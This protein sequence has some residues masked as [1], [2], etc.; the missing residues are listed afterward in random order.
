AMQT[1]SADPRRV[2]AVLDVHVDGVAP[3][4]AAQ[5]QSSLEAQVDAKHYRLAP[6][7]R[8]RDS[9]ANSTRWTDGCVVGICLAEV[10]AKTGA[11]LVLLAALTGS[12]T[13]FGFVV[14][15]VR[16]D[17]GRVLAQEAQRCEVCTVNEVLAGST[18]ATIKLLDAVPDS[19]PD[20]STNHEV[21]RAKQ[22]L[23]HQM[24]RARHHHRVLG[25]TL[26][27]TGIAVAAAGIALYATQNHATYGVATAAAGGGLAL[28][29]V[30][31]LAF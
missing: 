10:K 23:Q 30:V 13:S 27:F 17:T 9:M 12:G 26:T 28:G 20:D 7:A 25:A 4:V 6:R 16:T 21:E 19:L 5:F 2:V 15:L 1:A 29:G 31:S 8:V 14:T 3:E 18:L 22:P 11:D 24:T